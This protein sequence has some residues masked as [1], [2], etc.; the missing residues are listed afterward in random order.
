M[1]RFWNSLSQVCNELEKARRFTYEW[2]PKR[3][4]LNGSAYSHAR[5]KIIDKLKP[6][7]K[8]RERKSHDDP[9]GL[10][11][12]REASALATSS[13]FELSKHV[14][15]IAQQV[16]KY[17]FH[18][19]FA[20]GSCTIFLTNLNRQSALRIESLFFTSLKLALCFLF[21]RLNIRDKRQ[22]FEKCSMFIKMAEKEL[23]HSKF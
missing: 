6:S 3:I 13:S 14:F 19:Y 2:H 11:S 18:E 8:L 15:V 10:I 22:K 9:V 20:L 17:S 23:A 16:G 21:R 5:W 12:K 7:L 1:V 4:A